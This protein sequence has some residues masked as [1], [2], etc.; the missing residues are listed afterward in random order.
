MV[1]NCKTLINA[2]QVI[3]PSMNAANYKKRSN[4]IGARDPTGGKVKDENQ[5]DTVGFI[6]GMTD[7][8]PSENKTKT[9]MKHVQERLRKEEKE[10]WVETT[11]NIVERN[12]AE[13]ADNIALNQLMM[14]GQKKNDLVN[15]KVIDR[16]T[17]EYLENVAQKMTENCT[18]VDSKK[19]TPQQIQY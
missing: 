7:Y 16:I 3:H 14:A 17:A 15:V 5:P 8:K 9:T 6:L 1:T 4:R 10:A 11:K 13:E 19:L 2:N 18:N 12:N